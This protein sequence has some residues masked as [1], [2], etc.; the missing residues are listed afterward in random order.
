MPGGNGEGRPP[1]NVGLP[2]GNG[3]GRPSVIDVDISQGKPPQAVVEAI[4][5]DNIG[6][7]DN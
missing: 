6:K 5:E 7:L 1:I 4:S 3:G 2:G